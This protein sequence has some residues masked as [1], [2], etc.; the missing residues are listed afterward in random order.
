MNVYWSGLFFHKILYFIILGNR[1]LFQHIK[2]ENDGY[3]RDSVPYNNGIFTIKTTGYYYLHTFVNIKTGKIS[4]TDA[5]FCVIFINGRRNICR[6]IHVE[7]YWTG[8]GDIL[9]SRLY[10]KED[11]RVEVTFNNMSLVTNE[12]YRTGFNLRL[13]RSDAK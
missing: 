2:L 13:L 11:Q 7:P 4:P 10:L 3:E 1:L 8:T 12:V 6:Y 9:D 5:L